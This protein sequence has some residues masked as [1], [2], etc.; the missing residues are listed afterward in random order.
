M[1]QAGKLTSRL[2]IAY[3]PSSS[4]NIRLPQREGKILVLCKY[5]IVQNHAN[6]WHSVIMIRYIRTCLMASLSSSSKS[7]WNWAAD[8]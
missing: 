1:P 7:L 5:R 2:L 3:I 4:P 6:L 8:S